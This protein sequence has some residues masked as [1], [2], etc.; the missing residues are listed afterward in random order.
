LPLSFCCTKMCNS[1]RKTWFNWYLLLKYYTCYK[2][3]N[4]VLQFMN[5]NTYLTTK[6]QFV[7][8]VECMSTLLHIHG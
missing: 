4:Y 7:H 3:C 6:Y 5:K 8:P 2:H 1:F